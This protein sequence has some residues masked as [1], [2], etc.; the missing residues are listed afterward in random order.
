MSSGYSSAGNRS[1]FGGFLRKTRLLA[2]L[3]VVLASAACT[4]ENAEAIEDNGVGVIV[5]AF[6]HGYSDAEVEESYENAVEMGATWTR[7]VVPWYYVEPSPGKYNW[8]SIDKSVDTANKHGMNVLIQVSTAPEWATGVD[9]LSQKQRESVDHGLDTYAPRPEHYDDYA[10]FFAKVVERYSRKGVDDYEVWN[11]PGTNG[12]WKESFDERK[13]SPE[14]YTQLLKKTYPAAHAA[15]SNV[16]VIAGGQVVLPTE[17]DDTIVGAIDYLK[18]MYAAGAQGNFDS[19]AH[20]PYGIDSKEWLWN[21]W[22]YMFGDQQTS[23]AP[24]ESLHSIMRNHGDGHK[25]IWITEVGQ[26]TVRGTADETIQEERYSQYLNT[27]GQS[28][29]VGPILFYHIEDKKPYHASQDKED[30]FGVIREDGSWKPAAWAIKYY[31]ET[32][33]PSGVRSQVNALMVPNAK[34]SEHQDSRPDQPEA[35]R[36]RRESGSS[37][38]LSS[39][40]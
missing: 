6:D 29:N 30:Y 32:N 13:V 25:N 9:K 3:T 38:S 36:G 16:N 12:F 5:K 10:E 20:H 24:Q 22:D 1:R 4:P 18:R 39:S 2:V 8:D 15:H 21:G 34:I 40:R 35:A 17:P 31:T 11:E 28:H 19:L 33:P 7:V 37:L 23:N 14:S 27:W 26:D